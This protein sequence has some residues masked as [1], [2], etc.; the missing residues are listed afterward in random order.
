[1][2]K[3][4]SLALTKKLDLGKKRLVRLLEELDQLLEK[5]AAVR[6]IEEQLRMSEEHYR[7]VEEFQEEFETTL[8]DDE[9]NTAMDEWARFRQTFRES[10]AKAGAFIDEMRALDVIP[11]STRS[12][13]AD[14]NVRLP[15]CALPKFDGNVTKFRKFW[16][17]FE[18]SVHQQKD[19][20]DSVKLVYLRN[21]LTGDA[22][23]A[24]AGLTSA[25]ADY[26]VAV[27][28]IKE[29]FDRPIVAIRRL[30]LNLVGIPIKEW[31][32]KAL[33][34]HIDH[35]VDAL[36]ALGKD[37]RTAALTAADCLITFAR[38]LLPEQTRIKWDELTM[39]DELAQSD[40]SRFMQ[41]L[42]NQAELMQQN[43]RPSLLVS[44]S[45]PSSATWTSRKVTHLGRHQKTAT[46]LQ[47][48][49]ADRCLVCRGSHQASDCPAVWKK[50]PSQR[51]PLARKAGLCFQCL[52]PGHMAREC[53]QSGEEK[54]ISGNSGDPRT[55]R[56]SETPSDPPLGNDQKRKDENPVNMNLASLDKSGRTRMQ[57][58]RAIAY[59]EGDRK[60]VVN[61]LFGTGAERSFVREDVA[62]ELGLR[63]E[64]LSVEVHGFCGRSKG[65]QESLLVSFH[66]SSLSGEPRKPIKALTMKTLCNDIFQPR[67]LVRAWPH[68]RDLGLAD[69]E[70]ESLTVHVLIGVDYFFSMMGPTIV[71]GGDDGPVAVETCLGWPT[72]PP[73]LNVTSY[74]AGSGNLKPLGFPPKKKRLSVAWHE[75][76]L[77]GTS[78]L[79]GGVRRGD[80]ILLG[81]RLGGGSSGYRTIRAYMVPAASCC[82]SKGEHRRSQVQNCFRRVCTVSGHRLERPV[83]RWSEA[84]SGFI[85]DLDPLSA[86]RPRCLPVLVDRTWEEGTPEDI[87]VDPSL[88]RSHLLALSGYADDAMQTSDS[89]ITL[90]WIKA[91]PGRWKPFVANGVQEIQQLSPP[92]S[93]K[94]CPTDENPGDLL[95][96]GCSPHRLSSETLWWRGPRWLLAA[97]ASWP[98]LEVKG[99]HDRAEV[100]KE[101]RKSAVVVMAGLKWDVK[102][103]IDP[104]C[105]CSYAKLLRVTAICLRFFNNARLPVE[106]RRMLRGPTAVEIEEAEAVWIRQIQA[107][108][109]GKTELGNLRRKEL[110]EFCPYL[111]EREILRIGG[112]LRRAN[113]P[114][115]TKPPMLLPHGDEVV[116]MII[117]HVH[118]R[119]LRAGNVVRQCGICRRSTGRL[120]EP[121]MGELPAER[122]TPTGPFQY[123]GIDFA[124]PILARIGMTR[125]ESGVVQRTLADERIE[126]KFITERAPW[127]GGYWERLVQSVKVSLIKVLGRSRA[128]PE[129][130]RTMLCEIE[131]RINDRPLTMVSDRVD[132]EMAL[133]L[134]HFLI[135]RELSS[136]PDRDRH[137]QPVRRDSRSLALLHRRWRH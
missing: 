46:Y 137:C 75:R 8:N 37:P 17:Q 73:T 123:V 48:S 115:E 44:G 120:Y 78:R 24:I 42:R 105:Y 61:C 65:L 71:R 27:R 55:S 82:V 126:W 112:R 14:R 36:T 118:Q 135:G 104:T 19:L 30:L 103:T 59:G 51:R 87:Q 3:V 15:Q 4:K 97:E 85:E 117:R 10:K 49:V 11:G 41:F 96:R 94:H 25:N 79:M 21:C 29:R 16:D 100:E 89:T 31:D 12:A 18:S 116:K 5:Q 113:L 64:T 39:E 127:C 81:Q 6:E 74:C 70:E 131:A 34:D 111:D 133:T 1:M 107:N 26:Q 40:L 38:E 60:M 109:Y 69:E 101:R 53:G 33:S 20:A 62:Q 128:N 56:S 125:H 98:D 95:S 50:T 76:S 66:L 72:N 136:L 22:L 84:S 91:D 32:V 2:S 58:I 122:V 52:K 134:A 54:K 106:L 90:C 9:A 28:R 47:A 45:K 130:L 83:G 92:D 68:L 121:K 23:A 110:N 7:Q 86:V 63:G 57:T 114:V 99:G 102:K 80:L 132:D 119:Q 35:N 124:G 108:A 88:L 129:E 93:W 43:R 77:N 13:E 67:I